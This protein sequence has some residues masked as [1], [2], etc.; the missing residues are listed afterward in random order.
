[1]G[2][3]FHLEIGADRIGRL[4]FDHPERKVNVFTRE[5]LAELEQLLRD[6]P[7]HGLAALILASG[8][9]DTFIAGADV[10]EIAEVTDPTLAAE[11][12]RY[13]HR[14]FA[15][16]EA[17]PF[18]TIAAIR[19]T[20][21]GGG[22]ELA[23]ASTY[24]VVSDRPEVR[25]GLP[26]VRLGIVP[27][28]GGCV[29]LPR[30]I[31]IAA[32]LDLILTGKLVRGKKALE[33]GLA[34]AL[35]PDV[36][37]LA[38]V[39]RFARERAGAAAGR[40]GSADLREL[41]LERNPVGRLVLFDQARK[42]ALAKTGGHYPAPLRAIEVVRTAIA[43]GPRAGFD[44]EA[45]AI[46]ELATGPVSK[47]LV[48]LFRLMEAAKR[49][50]EG[51]EPLPV[52]AVGVLGAGVMGGGIAQLV[53]SQAD[54][55]V[56]FKDLAPQ[57]LA[58]G[59]GH[60]AALFEKDVRRRRLARVQ[61]RRRLALIRPTLD[62]SGFA[63]TDLVI[64]AVV[65]KLEVKQR[66]FAQLASLA[67]PGAVLASNTSSLSIDEIARDTPD[68]GRVVGMHFFNPVDKMPL[69]EVIRG[70]RTR[71]EAVATVAAFARRL[72]KTPVVVADAPGFLV[73]RLLTFYMTEAIWL[74]REGHPIEAIDEAMTTWGMPMGPLAL[75]DEVGLDVAT[76][77]AHILAAAFGQRLELPPGLDTLVE[78]G[79]LGSKNGSGLY[80]YQGRRRQEPDVEVYRLLGIS[81]HRRGSDPSKLVDRMVLPMINEAARCL[82]ERVV[83]SPGELDLA[84]IMG[85]G[86]PPFRGGLCRWVDTIGAAAI[87][88]T[89]ERLASSVG[90][91][92]APDAAFLRVA[93]AG[94]F[95]RTVW[96]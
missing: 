60:A 46:G 64:E 27:G 11:G 25:I 72:G 87:V 50:P 89:M 43:D 49:G 96:G 86:F 67:P 85:T 22:T 18:P 47:S 37:F 59:M 58:S 71:P 78:K 4:T 30:R 17:L 21:V 70:P 95:Y 94:G 91:R 76:K 51:V 54:L 40:R 90:R 83:A 34:D 31:G 33:L 15:A 75:A 8:K 16:W 80:R 66:V 55:P 12:S 5:V 56:R 45:R 92:F 35:L 44:A 19:G 29:R 23:L 57:A 7:H 10:D 77:V 3:A 13:G 1:V 28:W 36:G 48:H 14:L 68:P 93:A 42:Q 24:L 41:L 69:V 38:A 73:N 84:M 9:R 74:L 61:A 32:S 79:R 65:E 39:E 82:D 20:C 81:P 53:A 88:A 6:L 52:T 63:R 26:E 62:D 2:N